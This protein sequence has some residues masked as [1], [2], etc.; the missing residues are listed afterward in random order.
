MNC[1]SII[2]DLAMATLKCHVG[3]TKKQ[4]FRDR[5]GG[6]S[7]NPLYH[8]GDMSYLVSLKKFLYFPFASELNEYFA[9]LFQ[10]FIPV[11][12]LNLLHM[13][14]GEIKITDRQ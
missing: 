7:I 14:H 10:F 3:L 12:V 11:K 1:V 2:F 4:H 5:V 6:G 8:G 13:S 9:R